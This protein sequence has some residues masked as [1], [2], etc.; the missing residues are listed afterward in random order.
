MILAADTSVATATEVRTVMELVS[1]PIAVEVC[2]TVELSIKA[3]S[4]VV[5]RL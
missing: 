5:V 1:V 4:M 2:H 3:L